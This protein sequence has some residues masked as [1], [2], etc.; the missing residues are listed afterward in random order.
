MVTCMEPEPEPEPAAA[1]GPEPA[2]SV[3]RTVAWAHQATLVRQEI[4]RRQQ[5]RAVAR[6]R[7]PQLSRA[8]LSHATPPGGMAGGGEPASARAAA[9]EIISAS[10]E[11]AA[12]AE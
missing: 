11:E 1:A 6:S 4:M 8:I 7:S 10:E 5:N 3:A 9:T 12:A 2:G